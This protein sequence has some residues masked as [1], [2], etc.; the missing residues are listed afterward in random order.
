MLTNKRAAAALHRSHGV[1][2]N[3]NTM[4]QKAGDCPPARSCD[5]DT[6]VVGSDRCVFISLTFP[7]TV[8]NRLISDG[9]LKNVT[10]LCKQCLFSPNGKAMLRRPRI[11]PNPYFQCWSNIRRSI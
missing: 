1:E 6:L 5:P 9:C 2:R 7:R 4:L 8:W 3:I 10:K 11:G